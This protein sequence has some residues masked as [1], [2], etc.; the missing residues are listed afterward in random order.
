MHL[1]SKEFFFV[2]VMK[3][4]FFGCP[5]HSLVPIPTEQPLLL[6]LCN[7]KGDSVAPGLSSILQVHVGCTGEY[8]THFKP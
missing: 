7:N 3:S 2:L 4:L 5:G 8:C 1:K 6:F